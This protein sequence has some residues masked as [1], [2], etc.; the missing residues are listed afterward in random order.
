VADI[1]ASTSQGDY[2]YLR[3]EIISGCCCGALL[4]VAWVAS[5]YPSAVKFRKNM[6]VKFIDIEKISADNQEEE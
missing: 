4:P 5:N 1:V 3:P 2:T 6:G